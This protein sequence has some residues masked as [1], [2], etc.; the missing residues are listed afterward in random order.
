[1]RLRCVLA[2]FLFFSF[3]RTSRTTDHDTIVNSTITLF[4]NI[5]CSLERIVY[6]FVKMA[7]GYVHADR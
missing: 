3:V 1:M 7:F 2:V 4:D 6:C 5:I